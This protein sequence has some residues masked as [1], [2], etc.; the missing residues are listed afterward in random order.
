MPHA[1]PELQEMTPD[2]LDELFK[3]S[4]TGEIP[5]GEAKG[6]MLL[7]PGTNVAEWCRS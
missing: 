5:D 2:E 1:V 3:R 7:A 4:P 6:I